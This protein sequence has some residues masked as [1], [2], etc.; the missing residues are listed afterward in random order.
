MDQIEMIMRDIYLGSF[1]LVVSDFADVHER[2]EWG[3]RL[4][5]LARRHDVVLVRVVDPFE[6][7][8][9]DAGVVLCSDLESGETRELDTGSRSVR[10]KWAEAA[11]QR[12]AGFQA[13]L[14]RSG[15]DAIE[16][17]TARDVGAPVIQFFKQR[18]RRR[19][20]R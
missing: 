17:S 2:R 16:L 5:P 4:V 18:R 19:G 9:P 10:E 14:A 8:L 20:A 11:A 3:D 1:I 12:R 13:L 6:E 15:C 7:E